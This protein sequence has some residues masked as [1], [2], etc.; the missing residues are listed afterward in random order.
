[1]SKGAW[2]KLP[3]AWARQPRSSAEPGVGKVPFLDDLG[4]P[5][6][7]ESGLI[8]LQWRQHKGSATA[9]LLIL[10][11][12]AVISNRAQRKDGQRVDEQV[13][14]TY[15]EIH[16]MVPLS[17]R[18]IAD[19]LELLVMVKAIAKVRDGRRNLYTLNGIEKNGDWCA[20][21]QSHMQNFQP[22]LQRLR[23]FV[24]Y[25]RQPAS[26]HALKL[27][28]LVLAFRDRHTNFAA[29]G[30]DKIRQYTGLRNND[31]SK[32]IQLLVASELVRLVRD[33]EQARRPADP[34]H[35]RYAI[36][37]LASS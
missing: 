30:Y 10:F 1:M 36:C 14:A 7:A 16:K 6:Y 24:D 31:I 3:S 27:Y 20:F 25:L 8:M 15:P 29:I 18:L 26:L 9:A 23:H 2:A 33:D 12:L 35:N 28:M 4:N 17:R 37:G 5:H 32:A 19:G 34:H 21:P 13:A 11:A 22:H